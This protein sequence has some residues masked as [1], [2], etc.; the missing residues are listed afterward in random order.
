MYFED[1]Q[2]LV[3]AKKKNKKKTENYKKAIKK[4]KS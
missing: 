4:I 1:D 2:S 3:D